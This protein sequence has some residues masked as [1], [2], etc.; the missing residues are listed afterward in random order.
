MSPLG[1]GKR[2]TFVELRHSTLTLFLVGVSV[3][4]ALPIWLS[5]LRVRSSTP[6]VVSLWALVE[7]VCFVTWAVR[8]KN[9]SAGITLFIVGLWICNVVAAQYFGLQFFLYLFSLLSLAAS[10]LTGRLTAFLVTICSS[11]YMVATQASTSMTTGPYLPLLMTWLVLLTS[12]IAFHSLNEALD[13]A[14]SYQNYAVKQMFDAREHRGNLMQTTKVLNE[15]RQDLERANTQLVHAHK[16]AEE[17]RRLKAQFA[18][19]VSHELR[20]PINLIV[21]FAETIVISPTSYGTPL[22][23]A[24]WADMNTIY[25]SAKHLQSLI[26]DVLDVSQIEAGKMA[27]VK[28]EIDPQQVIG[29]AATLAR[30]LIESKGLTFSVVLP[31]MLPTMYLDRTRIRQVLINLLSNAARFTDSGMITL[32]ASVGKSELRISVTDTGIGIPKHQLSRV[33]EEFHQVE[34][35]LSRR[36]GGSGLGLTLSKQFVEL[37]GG[38]IWAE[39]EGLAGRGS[40]FNLTV[41]FIDVMQRPSASVPFP[42]LDEDA[43][44]FVVLDEDPAILQL[45]ERYTAKHRAVGVQNAD[46]ALR[47]VEMIHPA[48]LVL[49]EDCHTVVESLQTIDPLTPVITCAMPSG[50]RSIHND[51]AQFVK[52]VTRDTLYEALERLNPS[53]RNLLIIDKDRDVIRMFTRMLQAMSQRYRIWKAYS[54]EEGLALM[55]EQAP[56]V[57]IL[58]ILTPDEDGLTIADHM[59]QTPEL[60]EIPIIIAATSGDVDELTPAVNGKIVVSKAFQPVELVHCIEALVGVFSPANAPAP[61]GTPPGSVVS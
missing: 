24:Y 4:S 50:R 42:P 52:P 44:Y 59:K 5:N 7:L 29:E 12:L 19:N 28:E 22:P 37:H 15:V 40:T 54:S 60:T 3:S 41:P 34:G 17:A 58:D 1:R 38:R 30:D 33:F 39:S 14:W 46:E 25:R 32:S 23:P 10:V 49:D 57:V 55:R 21:G 45:F 53:A 47:L 6:E 43:R 13:M 8:R 11:A 61:S 26:N 35:S 48:A 16:A 27:I 36:Q 2:D 20:T 51:Q 9:L 18:A 31:E 56:D